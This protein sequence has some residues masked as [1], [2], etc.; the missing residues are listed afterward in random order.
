MP[1]L[2]MFCG[3]HLSVSRVNRQKLYQNCRKAGGESPAGPWPCDAPFRRASPH[4][5]CLEPSAMARLPAASRGRGPRSWWQQPLMLP[6]QG[7]ARPK[8]LAGWDNCARGAAGVLGTQG[9]C[10]LRGP[11]SCCCCSTAEK[12]GGSCW[13]DRALSSLSPSFLSSPHWCM[14]PVSPPVV[15]FHALIH[16]TLI[17]SIYRCFSKLL[18]CKFSCRSQLE[19]EMLWLL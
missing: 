12:T 5:L 6:A 10:C 13:Q 18:F 16:L 2:A 11:C 14:M 19:Q 17:L 15:I 1:S 7:P 3:R 4:L 9:C 8:V